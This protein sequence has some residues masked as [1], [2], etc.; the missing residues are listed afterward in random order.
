MFRITSAE[1]KVS[2]DIQ[3]ELILN[4]LVTYAS[5]DPALIPDKPFLNN[6]TD[7]VDFA[8]NPMGL[9]IMDQIKSIERDGSLTGSPY[10]RTTPTIFKH[11]VM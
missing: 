9:V 8:K 7:D 11:K 1:M 5:A 4:P 6:T 2:A 10:Y 3:S